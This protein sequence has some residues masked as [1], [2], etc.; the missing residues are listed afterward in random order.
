[1]KG[2]W[3]GIGKGKKEGK[4]KKKRKKGSLAEKV[5]MG[6]KGMAGKRKEGRLKQKTFPTTHKFFHK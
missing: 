4:R 2:K 5:E 1:M 6:R 3:K